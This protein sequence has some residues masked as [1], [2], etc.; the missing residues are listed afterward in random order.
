[1]SEYFKKLIIKSLA[2]VF[3]YF[4]QRA[5]RLTKELMTFATAKARTLKF[6]MT[7]RPSCNIVN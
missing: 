1:M 3:I 2:V 6:S 7:V 4:N 5:K